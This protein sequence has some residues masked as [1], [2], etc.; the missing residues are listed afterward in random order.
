MKMI[1]TCLSLSLSFMVPI[2]AETKVV[3]DLGGF[4]E[5]GESM[6]WSPLFQATWDK[7]NAQH[8][9]KPIKVEPEN[10]LMTKLDT[11]KWDEQAVM[12]EGGYA[13]FAGPATKEFASEG[14]T[15]VLLFLR[16]PG[17]W[18]QE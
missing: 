12:P 6:I 14:Q 16:K 5:R 3:L 17:E 15:F 1:F 9:G 18:N 8:K 11:F 10:K 4:P 7:W 2:K 13:T